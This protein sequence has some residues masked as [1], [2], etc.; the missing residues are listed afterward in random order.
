MKKCF[1]SG[2]IYLSLSVIVCTY[3]V[4]TNKMLLKIKKLHQIHVFVQIC[5]Q[6]YRAINLHINDVSSKKVIIS[7]IGDHTLFIK[8]K[9][10]FALFLQGA[11][12]K[13]LYIYFKFEY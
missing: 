9:K 3:G 10:I 5:A 8:T 12:T 4:S 13:S 6:S 2:Y 11:C 7:C 1:K